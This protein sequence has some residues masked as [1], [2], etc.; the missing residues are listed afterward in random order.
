MFEPDDLYTTAPDLWEALRGTAPI[1]VHQF[2]GFMDAGNVGSTITE[3]LLEHCDHEV[4]ARFDVDRLH[5]YR[6]RRPIMT[7]DTDHWAGMRDP[8]LVIERLEDAAGT[9]FLLFHGPEPDHLWRRALAAVT[10]M[11]DDL[12]LA[13][14]VGM[15]G[16]PT[17]IPHTRPTLINQ[18]ASNLAHRRENATEF[19]YLQLPASFGFALEWELA[20]H[21]T[22]TIG[23]AVQV[24]HYLAQS[25][26]AQAVLA[27]VERLGEVTGLV[28]PTVG[29][30]ERVRS[31]LAD[32]AAEAAESAEVQDVVAQLEHQYDTREEA[33]PLPSADEIGA[34]LE[35]FLAEQRGKDDER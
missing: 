6:S 9:E 4:V 2:D 31:N 15:V 20:Q 35:R 13:V 24:P 21:G 10:A 18:H 29:L 33:G 8:E 1:L 3:H 11:A 23:L 27:G 26:F 14:A 19:G 28:L 16:I 30:A 7:Y 32:I 34:E 5:D 25:T 17:G 12:D 22:D